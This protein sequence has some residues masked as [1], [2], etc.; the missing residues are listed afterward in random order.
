MFSLVTLKLYFIYS[1]ANIKEYSFPQIEGYKVAEKLE[2]IKHTLLHI[3]FLNTS[4]VL[5]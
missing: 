5:I 1:I 3:S 2:N 4:I